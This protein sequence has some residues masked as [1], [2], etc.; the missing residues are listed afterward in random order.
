M[1]YEGQPFQNLLI[2]NIKRKDKKIKTIGI[3]NLS[4]ISNSFI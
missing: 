4:T 2:R 3:I 1:S